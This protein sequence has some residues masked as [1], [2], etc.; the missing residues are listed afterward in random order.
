MKLNRSL[1]IWPLLCSLAFAQ[2]PLSER[3][4]KNPKTQHPSFSAERITGSQSSDPLFF[5]AANPLHF[6]P[7]GQTDAAWTIRRDPFTREVIQF[8]APQENANAG[9]QMYRDPELSKY[10]HDIFSIL[11][12]QEEGD[13]L[14]ETQRFTDAMGQT[15]IRLQHLHQGIAV[16]AAEYVLHFENGQLRSGNGRVRTFKTDKPSRLL[17]KA[18]AL[19]IAEAFI[20]EI[21]IPQSENYFTAQPEAELIWYLPKGQAPKQCYRVLLRPNAMDW[22]RLFVDAASGDVLKHE[23]LTCFID[24]PKVANGTDLHGKN[25]SLNTYQLGN[26]YYLIDGSRSMFNS[27]RSNLPDNPVG[28]IWTVDAQNTYATRIAQ[29]SNS[30]NNWSN[31]TAVSAHANAA[32]AYEYFKNVHNRNSINGQGGNIISVINV[33]DETGNGLDNA[34]WNGQFMAYGNGRF[35]FKPLARSM[36][37]AGHEMTHGVI[38]STAKLEYEDQP[39]AVNES[40]ADVFGAMM[41]RD[42]WL[43]GEDVVQTAYFPS[44][45]LRSMQDPHNGGNGSSDN[46]WQPKRMSEFVNTTEDNGGVH[47]NSGIPNHACYLIAESIGREKT[48]K[49][50]YRALTTY[51]GPRSEF[52]DLRYA[53]EQAAAD[54]HGENSTEQQ[55]IRTAFNQVEIYDPNQKGGGSGAGEELPI[56]PGNEYLLSYDTDP[57]N[58]NTLYKSSTAGTDYEALSN[59]SMKRKPSVPDQATYALYVDDADQIRSIAL[60]TPFTENVISPDAIWDN[61]AISK[62]GKML[63]AITTEIDTSIYIYRYDLKEWK[64][65]VLYN[66]TYSQGVKTGGVL[67]ADAIEFDHSGQYLIYDAFNKIKNPTGD[68][69]EYW[70]VGI[71]RVWNL[72]DNRWG[73]GKIEKVFTQL[74]EGVSIGNPTFS[75]NSTEVIAFDYVNT[76]DNSYALIG[77]NLQKGTSEVIRNN[78]KLGYPNYSNKDDKLLFDTDDINDDPVVAYVPL[79]S[80]KISASGPAQSLVPNARW[81]IW[82]ADGERRLLSDQKELLSFGFPSLPGSPEGKINGTEVLVEVPSNTDLNA[83]IPVFTLSSGASARV[84][85]VQ[86]ISG[87]SSQNFSKEVLYVIKAPDLSTSTYKVRVE[88]TNDIRPA[89]LHDIQIIPNPAG[90]FIRLSGAEAYQRYAIMDLSGRLIQAGTL[91]KEIELDTKAGGIYFLRLLSDEQTVLLRFVVE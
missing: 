18:E 82:Y 79:G 44:G 28:A 69:L 64:R 2:N 62:D 14:R 9:P 34:F 55:A 73:D 47:I 50:Y 19:K 11:N 31:P 5:Q 75:K 56:N 12:L 52:L 85:G 53:L 67:Y 25:R 10:L 24:G 83:L 36:D 65:F 80:N 13:E 84:G 90:R 32:L 26:S 59:K 78:M 23:N 30:N 1:L 49:I 41:D 76:S 87:S 3:H 37:V 58:A 38:G 17:A 61:V 43:I 60:E 86:Q 72:E 71:M 51:L 57:F 54:L 33:S 27:S 39:G 42:D 81:G 63:A 4:P 6:I 70:D 91:E 8:I 46:G 66:P 7:P 74:D 88:K 48:E 35:A 45:A 40:F 68:D 16:H 15:H 77:H 20:E 22:Y 29:I 89:A 21:G